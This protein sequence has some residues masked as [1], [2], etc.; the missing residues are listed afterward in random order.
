MRTM[1]TIAIIATASFLMTA[2]AA[3]AGDMKK[4][5]MH[6]LERSTTAP[7]IQANYAEDVMGAV[8]RSNYITVT[9]ENGNTY[10]NKIVNIDELPNPQLDLETVETYTYEYQG[11][12]YTNRVVVED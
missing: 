4:S 12:T 7:Y 9:D 3:F 11:R 5:E 1:R 2:P 8:E 10:L 6:E